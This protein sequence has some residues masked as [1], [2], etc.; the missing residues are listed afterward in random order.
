MIIEPEG[1]QFP[2]NNIFFILMII[3]S[4]LSLTAVIFDSEINI[5]WNFIFKAQLIYFLLFL[6]CKFTFKVEDILKTIGI[7]NLNFIPNPNDNSVGN[8]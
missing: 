6:N 3:F 1:K 5:Y 2:V 8:Y 7:V 4:V